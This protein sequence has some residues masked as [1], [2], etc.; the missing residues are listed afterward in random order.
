MLYYYSITCINNSKGSESKKSFPTFSLRFTYY[1]LFVKILL[2]NNSNA[3][4]STNNTTNN[5]TK[6]PKVVPFKFPY[7]YKLAGSLKDGYK[8]KILVGVKNSVVSVSLDTKNTK[9]VIPCTDCNKTC[10]AL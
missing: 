5:T 2:A 8:M 3:T 9:L 6:G 4:N 1:L 10:S 7:V